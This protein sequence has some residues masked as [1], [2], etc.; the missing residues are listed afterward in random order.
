MDQAYLISGGLAAIF[1]G[2]S[3]L[4]SGA[5]VNGDSMRANFATETKEDRH[6]RRNMTTMFLLLGLPNLGIALL[7]YYL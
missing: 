4:T 1:I 3:M 6:D 5:L 2:L 7:F